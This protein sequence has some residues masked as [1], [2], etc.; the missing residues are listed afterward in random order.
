MSS[1]VREGHLHI[2]EGQ[3]FPP[4]TEIIF[5]HVFGAFKNKLG[6]FLEVCEKTFN[7]CSKILNIPI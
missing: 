7:L 1:S 6:A 2:F 4:R 3:L 5:S